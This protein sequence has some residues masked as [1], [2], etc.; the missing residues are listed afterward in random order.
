MT[1]DLKKA[2]EIENINYYKT[3]IFDKINPYLLKYF[4]VTIN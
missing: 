4:K 3:K 2:C 1:L